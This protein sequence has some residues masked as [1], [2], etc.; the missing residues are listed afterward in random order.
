MAGD[1]NCH[2]PMWNPPQYTRHDEEVDKLVD[3]AANLSLSL[4]IPL[5]MVTFPNVVT[6]IKLIWANETA[7][8]RTLKCGIALSHDQGSDHLPIET[9]LTSDLQ[10]L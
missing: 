4:L 7:A 2:H 10:K 5:G 6:A 8:A 9:L 1:F 3:L